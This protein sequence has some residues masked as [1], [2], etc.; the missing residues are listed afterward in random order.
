MSAL[1]SLWRARLSAWKRWSGNESL[2]C[3]DLVLAAVI[4]GRLPYPPEMVV[5]LLEDREP[6]L[7]DKGT[8]R[9]MSQLLRIHHHQQQH[10]LAVTAVDRVITD[11]LW[12]TLD[13]D[14][15]LGVVGGAPLP[16]A[17]A[18]LQAP[19]AVVAEVDGQRLL[20]PAEAVELVLS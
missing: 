12:T 16:A 6:V 18:P 15:Y 10:S 2:R 17:W 3:F 1:D 20:Y 5:S 19:M 8:G 11:M 4:A 7:D 14:H 9:E 13:A